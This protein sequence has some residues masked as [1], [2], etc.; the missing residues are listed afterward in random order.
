MSENRTEIKTIEKFERRRSS[1]QGNPRFAVI[2]TD[3]TSSTTPVNAQVG[4]KVSGYYEGRQVTVEFDDR[5]QVV[6]FEE[7]K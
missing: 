7:V 1:D 4:Y 2:F 5:G 3:G 6:D